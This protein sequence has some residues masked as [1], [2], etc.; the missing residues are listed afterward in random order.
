MHKKRFKIIIIGLLF[1]GLFSIPLIFTRAETAEE[2]RARIEQKN[3]DIAKLEEELKIYQ[4][5]LAALG[6]Q[7]NSLNVSVK[8]LDITKKKL[9]TDISVTQNKIDKISFT[10]EDLTSD[11][12]NK[13]GAIIDHK[14][15]IALELRETNEFENENIIQSILSQKSF[16]D[17]WNDIDNR[18]TV[19]EKII[20][21]ISK[22]REVKGLLEDT[23]SSTIVAKNELLGLKT[24]LSDQQKIVAQNVNEKNKLLTQTKN[25][26]TAYQKLVREQTAKKLAFEQELRSYESQLK[27]ILDPSKLPSAGVLSWPLDRIY[28]T[29]QFGAK[30]GPHRTYASGHSGT[31]FRA[32]TPLPV[33]AMADGVIKGVGDTDVACPG[34]SFGKWVVIEYSNGL[35][36]TYGHLSL[37]KVSEGQRVKR[38]ETVAYSGGTGRS[39]APHLHISLYAANA[40]KVDAVPSV[41][42][43]GKI[44][45]QPIAAINA[46]LDPMFYLPPYV[47]Q[48]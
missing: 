41:S 19:R 32:R 47:P 46:Y 9:L 6:Q 35:A 17:V 21:N 14:N 16:T 26:E 43:P 37:I 15:S 40:V 20:E 23:R 25:S 1:I 45:K 12:G 33:Y 24:N 2:I 39:T 4:S 8:Q 29:Q 18:A 7:K 44:L 11:I 31:D 10:I 48:P 42:C 27:F 28:V 5:Q 36:S 13:E 22:L 38:G 3:A 34:V 30:T